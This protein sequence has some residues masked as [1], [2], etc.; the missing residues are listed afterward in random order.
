[1]RFTTTALFTL[2]TALSAVMA[3]P[4]DLTTRQV[5]VDPLEVQVDFWTGP[6]GTGTQVDSNWATEQMVALPANIDNLADSV[7]VG[8]DGWLVDLY[9]VYD[10]E[11]CTG[12]L[13]TY[14]TT[15]QNIATPDAA[16]CLFL[17][18]CDENGNFCAN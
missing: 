18:P 2:T 3:S 4:V 5:I 15:I 6:S 11:Q 16:S 7:Q 14:S 10:S 8:V 13:G 12:F 17:R 1:M 9:D